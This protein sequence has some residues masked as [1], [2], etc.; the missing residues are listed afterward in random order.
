MRR[1]RLVTMLG[2]TTALLL[3]A[4]STAYALVDLTPVITARGEQYR[5]FANDQYIAYTQWLDRSG[6]TAFAKA[7]GGSRTTLNQAGTDGVTG[8]FDPGTNTV[9][10]QQYTRRGSALYF[11]DLD[12]DL[13]SKAAG[14]NSRLWEWGPQISSTFIVYARDRV[15]RGNVYTSLVVYN[16]H[17]D[18]TRV[19]GTWRWGPY[20]M[21]TGSAGDTYVAYTLCNRKTCVARV[22]DWDTKSTVKIPTVNGKAQYAPVVDETNSAVYFTRSSNAACG[23][24]VDIW[25]RPFPINGGDTA[26]KI[27]DIPAGVDTGWES[28]LTLNGTSGDM[29]LY[30][31]RYRCGANTGDIYVAS[32]VSAA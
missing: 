14:V 32:G 22:Y 13:R 7:F 18:A 23:R 16:R 24:R 19:L 8:G 31:E 15:R 26:V 3:L 1:S 12:T 27:V 17:S 10:Y 9:L 28:S 11:Y 20:Q 2:V 25:R 6:N 29:D 4:V 30:I 21:F 5:A